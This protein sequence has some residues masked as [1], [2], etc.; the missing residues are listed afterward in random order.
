MQS[1]LNTAA[2]ITEITEKSDRYLQFAFAV[3]DQY[4]E[5][6]AKANVPAAALPPIPDTKKRFEMILQV[7]VNNANITIPCG[8]GQ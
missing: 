4:L 5:V 2:E 7:V 3:E 1:N 6:L 8:I